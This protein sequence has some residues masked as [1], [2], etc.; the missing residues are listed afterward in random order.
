M[1]A[2]QK[3]RGAIGGNRK[4]P[5]TYTLDDSSLKAEGSLPQHI[6]DCDRGWDASVFRNPRSDGVVDVEDLRAFFVRTRRTYA[7]VPPPLGSDLALWREFLNGR[8]A[9]Q[10]EVA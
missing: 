8:S 6:N 5:L 7:A 3:K 10:G 2:P 9:Q 1:R 4:A